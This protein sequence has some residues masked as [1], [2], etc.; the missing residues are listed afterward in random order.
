M[1]RRALSLIRVQTR[2]GDR[3]R[4]ILKAGPLT[5]PVVLGRTGI[6]ANKFEGDGATPR[7]RF[8]P[9][10][11]WWRADRHPRP[12]T[13]LPVRRITPDVAW[14]ENTSDRRYNQPFRRS[15]NDPGDRLW[16]QDHLYD[17]IVEIDHNTRP[18]I[19]KRGS[20]VFVHVARPSRSPTQ[21][22]VAMTTADLRRLL[23]S[24][25]RRT[26]IEIKL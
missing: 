15:A 2:P 10:R 21:G 20:A 9:L 25:G 23:A 24:L 3:T 6:R 5:I 26:R 8:R 11:L 17:L 19:A 1:R 4:G 13:A 12:T 14:C 16:R 18:R 22:C 7:G